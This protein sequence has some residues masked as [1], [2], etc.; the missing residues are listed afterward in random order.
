MQTDGWTVS[1]LLSVIFSYIYMIKTERKVVNP[2]K[3]KF[4]K[5]FVGDIINMKNKN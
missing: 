1:G 2:S 4:Y 5:R 3:P